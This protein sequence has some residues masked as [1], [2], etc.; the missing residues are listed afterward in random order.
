MQ[1]ATEIAQERSALVGEDRREAG[2]GVERLR[3]LEELGG[4]EAPAADR[5]VDRRSD[6]ACR[7]DPCAGSLLEEVA[8]LVGLV[9]AAGDDDRV[10]RRFQRLGQ[11][12]PGRERGRRREARPDGRELEQAERALVHGHPDRQRVAAG[13]ETEGFPRATIRHGREVHGSPA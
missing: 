1:L 7:A 6:V 3:D 2:R 8:G 11:T 10:A 13:P 4:L 9:Q 5:P 12:T